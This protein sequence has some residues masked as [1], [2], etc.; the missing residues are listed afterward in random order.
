VFALDALAR[1]AGAAGDDERAQELGEQSDRRMA[2]AAHFITDRDRVDAHQA[3]A[4][5]PV[6]A[7][8]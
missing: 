4:S 7:A 1:L 6:S 5:A 2:A 3:Q 8:G